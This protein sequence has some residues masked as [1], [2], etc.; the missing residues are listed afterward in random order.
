M[1][2]QALANMQATTNIRR[3][4]QREFGSVFVRQNYAICRWPQASR[5]GDP[6]RA[7]I[8]GKVA[9]HQTSE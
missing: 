5:L 8:A 6:V 3:I 7:A 1:I 2:K 4:F 9:T